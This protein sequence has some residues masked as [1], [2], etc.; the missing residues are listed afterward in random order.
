MSVPVKY[1]QL[2]VRGITVN[3]NLTVKLV[4]EI[5][6]INMY[7][8]PEMDMYIV[9]DEVSGISIKNLDVKVFR[10]P[11]DALAYWKMLVIEKI[12]MIEM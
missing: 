4:M 3:T 11:D 7:F 6:C 2:I 8:V 12:N 9:G 5:E 1:T 10:N